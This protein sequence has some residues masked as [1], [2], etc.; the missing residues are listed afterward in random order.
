MRLTQRDRAVADTNIGWR[1]WMRLAT[2]LS[3]MIV[4][5][6]FPKQHA[7]RRK[8]FDDLSHAEALSRQIGSH[9]EQ[10]K[11]RAMTDIASACHAPHFCAEIRPNQSLS[12]TASVGF[13][14]SL[15]AVGMVIGLC[16]AAHGAWM[17]LPFAGLELVIV[18]AVLFTVNRRAGD[19]ELV[20]IDKHRVRLTRRIRGR[21]KSHEFQRYWT[22]VL[23]EP[24]A[25]KWH[26]SRLLIGSHG[27][28]V[29]LGG[30]MTEHA[31]KDLA[32]RL[33]VAIR[34]A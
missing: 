20:M 13:F 11:T 19:Y 1:P 26:P 27:R 9:R 17:V 33:Q 10:I 32:E 23:L 24:G 15:V 22:R 18:A 34:R 31:R 12:P 30:S 16:L 28:L 2:V 3:S 8:R 5:C 29:A 14:L 21:Q 6:P 4:S 25:V 7:V